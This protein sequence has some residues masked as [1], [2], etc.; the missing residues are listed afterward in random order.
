MVMEKEGRCCFM[1]TYQVYYRLVHIGK[2]IK[3][4]CYD[5]SAVCV[6]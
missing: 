4:V 3:D 1:F 2:C 6:K 5:Y